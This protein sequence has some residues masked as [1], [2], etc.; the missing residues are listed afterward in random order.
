M[1]LDRLTT[2]QRIL[3][4]ASLLFGNRGYHGTSTRQI[5]A[6]VGIRQPSLFYH[7]ES[8]QEILAALINYD[9]GEAVRVAEAEASRSGSPS[10]RLYRYL[11]SDV[12][13]ICRSPYYLGRASLD[14]MIEEP[15][16]SHAKKRVERL[17][18]ARRA[19]IEEAVAASEFID[20]DPY[21][22]EQVIS[23]LIVGNIVDVSGKGAPDA[24]EIA[25]RVACFALRG[26]LKDP[27]RIDE[28]RQDAG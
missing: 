2:R 13:F 14:P 23:W 22:A 27:D 16:F 8:K 7:F 26:L 1:D 10:V 5:A 9:L 21:F 19:M 4:E 15:A 24:D 18:R 12:A 28:I 6:A 20:L 11:V 3:R 25:D 17:R